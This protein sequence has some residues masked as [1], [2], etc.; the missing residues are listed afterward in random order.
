MRRPIALVLIL[1]VLSA[2]CISH[3]TKTT[4]TFSMNVTYIPHRISVNVT[5]TAINVTANFIGYKHLT[6]NNTYV[7][8]FLKAGPE[9]ANISASRLSRDIYMLSPYL[10][11]DPVKWYSTGVWLKNGS[12]ASVDI[13]FKG[14]P[15]PVVRIVVNYEVKKNG[16]HFIVRPLGWSSERLTLWNETFNVTLRFQGPIQIANAPEV[17][18]ENGTYILPTICREKNDDVTVIY[19]YSVGDIYIVGSG[20][21]GFMGKI[22]FPC[23]DMKK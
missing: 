19:R 21:E 14:I 22:Y 1:A 5:V 10:F 13:R 15:K 2:G 12:V 11:N 18:F 3:S 4:S 16:T 17:K 9:I 23:E 8:V 6:I 20:G 7:A